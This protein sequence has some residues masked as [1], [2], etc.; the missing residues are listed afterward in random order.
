MHAL[1]RSPELPLE[2]FVRELRAHPFQY[3]FELSLRDPASVIVLDPQ[4]QTMVGI[5]LLPI[6]S[7]PLWHGHCV[8][9]AVLTLATIEPR[10]AELQPKFETIHYELPAVNTRLVHHRITTRLGAIEHGRFFAEMRDDGVTH[11]SL[12]EGS[13]LQML[14]FPQE[15]DFSKERYLKEFDTPSGLVT[16]AAT[17]S[18]APDYT[19]KFMLLSQRDGI[20]THRHEVRLMLPEDVITREF[21]D[22]ATILEE[23]LQM[24]LA[25]RTYTAPLLTEYSIPTGHF[26]ASL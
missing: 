17:L 2:Q 12:Q 7:S 15:I 3:G 14:V 4:T 11:R 19:I 26:N 20:V 23:L 9:D 10:S 25:L 16:L 24:R 5:A 18:P 1:H 21:A 22:A 6:R 8:A 13:A